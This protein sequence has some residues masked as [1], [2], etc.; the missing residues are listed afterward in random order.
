MHLTKQKLPNLPN[1][2]KMLRIV[3]RKASV[4]AWQYWLC[5]Y[6]EFSNNKFVTGYHIHCKMFLF[7]ILFI[8]HL[9]SFS[10]SNYLDSDANPHLNSLAD[11]CRDGQGPEDTCLCYNEPENDFEYT[12]CPEPQGGVRL[13]LFIN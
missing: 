10:S 6:L 1:K 13:L 4:F 5:H 3:S 8:G 9:L 11:D 7:K 2:K 12:I